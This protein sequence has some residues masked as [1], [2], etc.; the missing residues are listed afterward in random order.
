LPRERQPRP[1]KRP[2]AFWA[3]FGLTATLLVLA[4]AALYLQG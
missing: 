2:A 4:C 3:L 1:L